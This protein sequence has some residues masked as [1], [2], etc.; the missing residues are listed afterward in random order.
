MV[1]D[2]PGLRHKGAQL[3]P[4]SPFGHL[5]PL[6]ASTH[7]RQQEMKDESGEPEQHEENKGETKERKH[8]IETNS[9]TQ[10]DRTTTTKKSN[11][12]QTEEQC[13]KE[14]GERGGEQW[15]WGLPAWGQTPPQPPGQSP[16]LLRGAASGCVPPHPRLGEKHRGFVGG[17]GIPGSCAAGGG[18]GRLEQRAPGHSF[19]PPASHL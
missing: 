19:V 3:Q 11:E 18:G 1:G 2:I 15:G 16:P 12:M 10:R 7:V 13:A 5:P 14:R 8:F 4:C 9:V 17:C 6:A